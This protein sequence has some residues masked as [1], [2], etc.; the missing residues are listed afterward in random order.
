M[1]ETEMKRVGGWIL[2]VLRTPDD[3]SLLDRV[4]NEIAEFTK[5]FPGAGIPRDYEPPPGRFEAIRLSIGTT[6]FMLP[7][8]KPSKSSV[9]NLNPS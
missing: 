8:R 2:Q 7:E 3:S 1:K 5:A 6:A 9:T 4:R